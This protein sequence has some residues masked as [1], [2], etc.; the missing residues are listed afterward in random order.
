M[1]L[2]LKLDALAAK[3]ETTYATDIVPTAAANAIRLSERLFPVLRISSQFPNLREDAANGQLGP[4]P[5]LAKH[6]RFVEIDFGVELT[7]YGA[8]YSSSNKPAASP[9]IRCCGMSEAGVFT[10]GSE[11]YTYAQANSGH[12]S[13]T[14]Y[15]WAAGNLYK[16]VGCRGSLTWGIQAGQAMPLRFRI[17]GLLLANPAVAALPAT[18]YTA[19]LPP[20]AVNSS[21]AISGWSPMSASASFEQRA[22]VEMIESVNANGPANDGIAEIVITDVAPRVMVTALMDPL[23]TMDPYSIART[24]TVQTIDWTVGSTQ[25]NRADL[26]V[27]GAYL[28]NDPGHQDQQ[29]LAALALEYACTGSPLYNIVFD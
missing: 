4:P 6:G 8:A 17:I 26:D 9:L 2:R 13:T 11:T 1:A 28:V 21:F 14:I 7:G 16:I 23:A 3:V 22:N 24:P 15:A 20:A 5:P 19:Q 29:G 18:T 27:N 25:Y 12:D 10:G